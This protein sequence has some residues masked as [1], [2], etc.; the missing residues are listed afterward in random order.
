MVSFESLNEQA[1][2]IMFKGAAIPDRVKRAVPDFS[3]HSTEV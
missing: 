2:E 3:I 1:M